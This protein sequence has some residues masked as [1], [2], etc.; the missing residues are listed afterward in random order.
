MG[1]HQAPGSLSKN[2]LFNGLACAIVK[3][4]IKSADELIRSDN[5]VGVPIQPENG[6]NT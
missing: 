5:G 3:P 1:N 6:A 2:G 4:E